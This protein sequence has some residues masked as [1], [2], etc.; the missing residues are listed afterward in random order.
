MIKHLT[1]QGN[2]VCLVIERPIREL[3]EIDTETPLKIS[4]EGRRLIVEPLSDE[5]RK[6]KFKKALADTKREYRDDLQRLSK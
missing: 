5:E 2:S 1:K 6:G 3:M 4:V